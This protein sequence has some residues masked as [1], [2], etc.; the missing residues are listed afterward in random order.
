MVET[1]ILRDHVYSISFTVCFPNERE[2]EEVIYNEL[3]LEKI[4]NQVSRLKSLF[5]F[6]RNQLSREIKCNN[7]I[8]SF[9][10]SSLTCNK[11]YGWAIQY[12]KNLCKKYKIKN[13][14]NISPNSE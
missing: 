3:K 2:R 1:Y 6:F 8:E 11:N 14:Y 4:K 13:S 5:C 10:S 12:S 7:D 9:L